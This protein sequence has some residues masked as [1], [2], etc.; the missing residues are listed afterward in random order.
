MKIDDT[1]RILQFAEKP[2]GSDL[3]TM[4]DNI[5]AISYLLELF[6]SPRSDSCF[7]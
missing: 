1:G 5:D 3:E 6:F 7:F 2:K 4:V